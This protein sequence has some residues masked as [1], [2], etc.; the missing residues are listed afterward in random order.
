MNYLFIA[1]TIYLIGSWVISGI[2]AD[3]YALRKRV[4]EQAIEIERYKDTINQIC[5]QHEAEMKYYTDNYG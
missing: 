4:K 2:L 5:D 3:R 1:I